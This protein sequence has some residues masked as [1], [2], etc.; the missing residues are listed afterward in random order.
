MF[1]DKKSVFYF[2][3]GNSSIVYSLKPRENKRPVDG[4]YPKKNTATHKT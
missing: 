3:F 2:Y 4:K 1:Q